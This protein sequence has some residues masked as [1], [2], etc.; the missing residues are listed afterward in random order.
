MN[1][2]LALFIYLFLSFDPPNC[3]R[4]IL[5]I[6]SFYSG[7]EAISEGSDYRNRIGKRKKHLCF[8]DRVEK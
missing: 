1:F 3:H 4:N 5:Y 8:F 7:I 6:L 2:F